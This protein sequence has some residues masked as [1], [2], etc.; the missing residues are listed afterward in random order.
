MVRGLEHV[1]CKERL[2]ELGLFSVRGEKAAGRP[3]H[4]LPIL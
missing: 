1:S 3:H 2:R 4:G